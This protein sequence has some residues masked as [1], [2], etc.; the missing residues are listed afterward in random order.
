MT[1]EDFS[2]AFDISVYSYAR[3]PEFG[4]DITSVNLA[5]DEYEK[6]VFLTRAQEAVVLALYNDSFENTE[7]IRRQLGALVKST[8]TDTQSTR[9]K[10]R[11]YHT[12]VTMEPDVWF[13]VYEKALS[14]APDNAC[15]SEIDMD[16]YP[17]THDEYQRVVRNPFR[18]PTSKRVLRI[19][20]GK[21]KVSL[22]ST[23]PLSKYS[24]EYL[25]KPLPIILTDLKNEGL[26]IE[27]NTEKTECQLSSSIHQS[28]LDTA[29]RI[30][31]SSRMS[32]GKAQ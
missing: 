30:A 16:V 15:E 26:T 23:V 11:L 13:V 12:L 5:F 19:D 29:V 21:L 2:N 8:D 14:A 18:G 6:S 10:D 4:Q 24:M 7:A 9:G 28:I 25:S 22:I 27:G 1:N 3:S 20:T 31:V 17:V 32:S